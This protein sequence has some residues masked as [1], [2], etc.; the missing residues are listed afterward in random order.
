MQHQGVIIHRSI[1][2]LKLRFLV[3]L[4]IPFTAFGQA[5]EGPLHPLQENTGNAGD[6]IDMVSGSL[7]QWTSLPPL[8]AVKQYHA[9]VCCDGAVYVFGGLNAD[10][11]GWDL[12]CFKYDIA[13][14]TWSS[15][16]PLPFSLSLPSAESVNGKI[17]ILGGYSATNP[18]WVTEKTVFEYDPATN[19][20]TSK[21]PM[22]FAVF[23]AASFVW[24]GR[25]WLLG[26]GTTS[27]TS[28]S[29]NIQ[30]YDP[31]KDKWTYS[32][33]LL[34]EPLRASGAAVIGS[35]VYVLGGAA[36]PGQ[37]LTPSAH[38]FSA[39]ISGDVI[40][41]TRLADFPIGTIHRHVMGTNGTK[42]YVTGGFDAANAL[43]RSMQEYD[44]VTNSWTSKEQKPTAVYYAGHLVSDASGTLYASGGADA[45]TA[46]RTMES[47][48]PAFIAVA[49]LALSR[50]SVDDWVQRGRIHDFPLALTNTGDA[51][52]SY[53]I[54]VSGGAAA[55][56][57]V[58][59]TSGA[60]QAGNSDGI[61]IRIDGSRLAV[62][63]N[64]GTM[65]IIS[66]DPERQRTDL[67]VRIHAQDQAVD[68][69]LNV[70]LE[71]GTGTWTGNAPSAADSMHAIIRR[72]PGRVSGIDYHGGNESEPMRTL[73]TE[74]WS[75]RAGLAVW[76]GGT[77]NRVRFPDEPGICLP[78]AQW[79]ARV[80]HLLAVA[81]SPISISIPSATWNTSDAKVTLDV[82][83]FFHRGYDRPVR[84]YVAQVQD[85]M[86]YRQIY[87]P[88]GSGTVALFPY[89]H[90]R[91][92]RHIY[93]D[94]L[95]DP[96][97][98]GV[99]VASQTRIRKSYTLWA[100]DTVRS[101]TRFVVFAVTADSASFG[102]VLQSQ[103]VQ[104]S[105]FVTSVSP[106]QP[107]EN[108]TL[109]Q[110]FPNP[111]GTAPNSGNPA[112]TIIFGVPCEA[113]VALTLTDSFGRLVATLAND[114]YAP[115]HHALSFPSTGLASG[116]YFVTMRAGSFMQT[117][118][119][120]VVR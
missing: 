53:T 54:T 43:N 16:A 70:L 51:E 115:G 89:F 82:E 77:I 73:S 56:L 105:N 112:T 114:R 27:F 37:V 42:V 7:K 61:D 75:T 45:S 68:T 66:N 83:V 33:S 2:A 11:T 64:T 91:V 12:S 20:Y 50:A 36:Y 1:T 55:W 120:T 113:H 72:H 40:T 6:R 31:S 62:G 111:F 47:F 44:P 96:V 38:F 48:N 119:I 84:L 8:P 15:I 26:G 81:R 39:G 95:G 63:E 14:K 22:P 9:S 93:P 13:G 19:R 5:A 90:D 110:N 106:S 58:T 118:I 60:V 74:F 107:E 34:P 76:P 85:S 100:G 102:E 10:A 17:Y 35:K 88:A 49:R 67:P 71:Q 117:R 59:K 18:A 87:Y 108:F 103:E 57:S 28:A 23:S 97:F 4:C 79:G 32:L 98:T 101:L 80:E 3:V 25:I 41:F 24:D 116:P 104:A 78:P 109:S 21:A 69:D 46:V 30:I 99:D 29:T 92:L 65:T 86:N 94:D 52:L